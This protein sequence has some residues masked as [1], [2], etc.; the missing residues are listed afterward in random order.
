MDAWLEIAVSVEEG[1][2]DAV[3]DMFAD[4][5]TGGVVI[6]DPAVIK[7]HAA[8]HHPDE[9]GIP[10][11]EYLREKT[12]IKAYLPADEELERRLAKIR[13]LLAG[14]GVE[15]E[16]QLETKTVREEDWATAWQA[17]YK[18][19]RVGQKLVIK[20]SWET[21]PAGGQDIVI[22]MDPGMAFGSGTHETTAMCLEL[23]EKHLTPGAAV[24]DVGA[25]T[26]ILAIA[27]AKLGAGEVS[28]TDNDPVACRVALDNVLRN[29]VEDK[30]RV[31]RGDLLEPLAASR[32]DLIV[33]NVIADVIIT[34]TPQVVRFLAPGGLFIASGI[35]EGR[36]DSVAAVFEE[37]GF[38]L[39][40]QLRQGNW[41][42]LA[43]VKN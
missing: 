3:A 18:P 37:C 33:A 39:R 41:V 6:E 24:F 20:P 9:W 8:R 10:E 4:M 42:A 5:R 27:A 15:T 32:A 38:T 7:Q 34:L 22:E 11:Q 36:R 16:T 17:Y 23:L 30:V 21:F 1:L 19:V 13:R 35:I 28:A 25:G 12:R 26:G 29:R 2:A 31:M 14:M 40:E 43:G